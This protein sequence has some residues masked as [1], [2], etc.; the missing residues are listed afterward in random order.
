M[1][2]LTTNGFDAPATA[3]N[4]NPIG[5][6]GGTEIEFL[7]ADSTGTALD[8]SSPPAVLDHT[9]FDTKNFQ[10]TW[11]GSSSTYFVRGNFSGFDTISA[12]VPEPATVT[13][14]IAIVCLGWWGFRHKRSQQQ[15]TTKAATEA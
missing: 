5:G 13:P 2:F 8:S 6:A 12:A 3:L 11:T 4:G 9:K 10:I 14:L 7:L 15:L 1:S